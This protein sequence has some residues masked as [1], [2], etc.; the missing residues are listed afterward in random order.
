MIRHRLRKLV[1]RPMVEDDGHVIGAGGRAE[2]ALR[3]DGACVDDF[4]VAEDLADAV[5][6]VEREGVAVA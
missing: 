2:G 1:R 4:G 3:T 5:A 6:R